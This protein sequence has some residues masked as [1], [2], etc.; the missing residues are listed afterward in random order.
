MKNVIMFQLIAGIVTIS[1]L[2]G[3]GGRSDVDD[4]I[5]K[6]ED[7]IEKMKEKKTD[8]TEADWT[9]FAEEI[10]EPCE[11]LKKELDE[12]NIGT[13]KKIKIVAVM[14]RLATV[15]GKAGLNAATDELMKTLRDTGRDAAPAE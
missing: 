9:A 8:L 3:C 14:T 10:K 7:A 2:S 12:G 1:L 5:A 4:S 11:I 6:I 15:A 13:L